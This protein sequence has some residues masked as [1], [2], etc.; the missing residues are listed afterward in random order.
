[1]SGWGWAVKGKTKAG[2]YRQG[3]LPVNQA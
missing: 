3:A 2:F 1:M